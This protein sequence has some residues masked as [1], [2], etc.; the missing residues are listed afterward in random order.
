MDNT[1]STTY[2]SLN[3]LLVSI[4]L[5]LHLYRR[6]KCHCAEPIVRIITRII[7]LLIDLHARNVLHQVLIQSLNML[8]VSDMLI[9]YCHLTATYAC[10][11][12]THTVVETD[13][14]MLIVWICITS[15]SS[16]PHNLVYILCI[17]ADEGTTTRSSN[18]LISIE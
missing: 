17:A 9:K 4:L 14:R 8:V 16:I 1:G 2:S 3:N 6:F 5:P 13:S 7:R 10:T 11:Y 12:I 15:L 18:H